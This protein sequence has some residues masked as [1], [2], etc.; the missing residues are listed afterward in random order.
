MTGVSSLVCVV[1]L[2]S[3]CRMRCMRWTVLGAGGCVQFAGAGVGGGAVG[4]MMTI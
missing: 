1:L 2:P 4:E 3:R